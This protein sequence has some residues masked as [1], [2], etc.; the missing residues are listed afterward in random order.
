MDSRRRCTLNYFIK[1]FWDIDIPC[2]LQRRNGRR[3]CMKLWGYPTR[4]TNKP[5]PLCTTKTVDAGACNGK[6]V[7]QLCRHRLRRGKYRNPW[8]PSGNLAGIGYPLDR[9][10]QNFQFLEYQFYDQ[11]PGCRGRKYLLVNIAN[12]SRTGGGFAWLPQK[13]TYMTVS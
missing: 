7:S 2:P 3:F 5:G 13:R 10:S 9:A 8:A 11:A 1:S 6:L 12:S 4:R